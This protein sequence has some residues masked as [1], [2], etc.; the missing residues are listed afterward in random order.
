MSLLAKPEFQMNFYNKM[1][2][3]LC[4]LSIHQ[5]PLNMVCQVISVGI[6]SDDIPM[7]RAKYMHNELTNIFLHYRQSRFSQQYQYQGF[8]YP[9]IYQ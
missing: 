9:M 7:Q 4:M 6:A 5:F 2:P 1:M 8:C 3:I